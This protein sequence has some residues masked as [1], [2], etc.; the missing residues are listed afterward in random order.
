MELN[1]NGN[2]CELEFMANNKFILTTWVYVALQIYFIPIHIIFI[3]NLPLAKGVFFLAKNK[4]KK[5]T[6]K[7]AGY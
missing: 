1:A 3:N 7:I 4:Q 2:E 6:C 5:I